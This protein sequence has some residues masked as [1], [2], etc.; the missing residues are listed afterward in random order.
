MVDQSLEARPPYL[1][2]KTLQKKRSKLKEAITR[3]QIYQSSPTAA[4]TAN[5]ESSQVTSQQPPSNS[6]VTANSESPP[7]GRSE[8][9]PE[10]S[11]EKDLLQKYWD[12]NYG[13]DAEELI[14]ADKTK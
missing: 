8:Q 12:M 7:R 9:L 2:D 13:M 10:I 4:A 14:V 5:S 1:T 3:Y 11:P 6:I